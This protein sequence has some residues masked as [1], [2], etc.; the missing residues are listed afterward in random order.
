MVSV[1]EV[2]E[3]DWQKGLASAAYQMIYAQNPDI[4]DRHE[5]PGD[6]QTAYD[7]GVKIK[8]L[9]TDPRASEFLNLLI[10]EVALAY[11]VE[12]TSHRTNLGGPYTLIGH[13]SQEIIE[14][15]F[16]ALICGSIDNFQ[17]FEKFKEHNSLDRRVIKAINTGNMEDTPAVMEQRRIAWNNLEELCDALRAQADI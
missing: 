10:T 7:L 14:F 1:Q 11:V 15:G 17:A 5:T 12:R 3:S 13:A 6:F 8:S 16:I 4:L 9:H 2:Y